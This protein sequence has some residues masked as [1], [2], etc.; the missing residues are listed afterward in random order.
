MIAVNETRRNVKRSSQNNTI[1]PIKP[2]KAG[3]EVGRVGGSHLVSLVILQGKR[4]HEPPEMGK[5]KVPGVRISL[6]SHYTHKPLVRT[7]DTKQNDFPVEL[8]H[9]NLRSAESMLSCTNLFTCFRTTPAH[10]PKL[11]AHWPTKENK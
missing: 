2:A 7:H 9:P 1:L 11:G 4:E 6:R 5:G 8:T 10:D 3:E